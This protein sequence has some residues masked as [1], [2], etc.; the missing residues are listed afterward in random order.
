MYLLTDPRVGKN[1]EKRRVDLVDVVAFSDGGLEQLKTEG[2]QSKPREFCKIDV[3][4][5][6]LWEDASG[7]A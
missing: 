3:R 4:S 6:I 2:M 1:A 5:K 7:T